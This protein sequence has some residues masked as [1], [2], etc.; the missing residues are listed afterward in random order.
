MTPVNPETLMALDAGIQSEVASYV[1]Y[2]EAAKRIDSDKSKE[3]LLNLAEEEKKHFQILEKQ[4]HSLVTSEKWISTAD[5]LKEPG[6]PEIGEEMTAKHQG[7]IEEV[8]LAEST[9]QV[10]EIA[11]RLEEDAFNLFSSQ[12]A[13]ATEDKAKR[14]FDMLARFE[15]GHMTTIK[16]MIDELA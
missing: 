16:G 3:I 6:L 12:A 5:V 11:Y 8:R 10:L 4:H 14:M 13:I 1:F 2:L 7:L 9:G 15:K